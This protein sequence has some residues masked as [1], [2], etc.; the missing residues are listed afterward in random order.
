MDAAQLTVS[1]PAKLNLFL[2]IL[3][4]RENGYHDLQTVFQFLD[5]GDTLHFKLT[6]K[7]NEISLLNNPT[8]VAPTDNLIYKA[9]RALQQWHQQPLPGVAI[10]VEKN[11][12]MGGGLGGGSSDAASTLLALRQLWQ[13]TIS[14][15]ELAE[16]GLALG[17]DVPVFLLGQAAFAEGIGERLQP[18][19]PEP[20][21]YLVI[22]PQVHVSTAEVF[23]HPQL[24][25]QT[26]PLTLQT[27][28]LQ[29]TRNDCQQLVSKLHPEVAKSIAWLL[30]YAPARLTG[31][32]ACVFGCF[33][34]QT[35][36][37]QALTQL[38]PQWNGFVARGLNQSP[39]SSELELA[40][41][42][43]PTTR[44]EV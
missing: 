42:S 21:W 16:L 25:R 7:S 20:Y 22:H 6:D 13:L 34:S 9:A 11:I 2:H 41:Q 27:W 17:A 40:M 38:P 44:P 3:G 30:E 31:T 39:V 33:T 35:E 10:A 15:A 29:N 26:S 1:A 37:M 12:P 24:P 8:A 32:G 4:R 18:V 36:A 23:Q 43:K 28:N 19:N 14:D 5:F